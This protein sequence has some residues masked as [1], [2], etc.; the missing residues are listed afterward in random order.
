MQLLDLEFSQV[1]TVLGQ[2]IRKLTPCDAQFEQM[3]F[4]IKKNSFFVKYRKVWIS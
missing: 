4:Q 1:I 2:F 3:P